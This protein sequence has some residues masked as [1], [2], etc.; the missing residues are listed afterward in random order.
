MYSEQ[1]GKRS[2]AREVVRALSDKLNESQTIKMNLQQRIFL[3]A[4]LGEY[5]LSNESKWM[6]TKEKASR[7][8]GWFIPEFIDIAAK[9]IAH[10]FLQKDVHVN[11]VLV[12]QPFYE[13]G[14]HDNFLVLL[15]LMV[16][17]VEE[18]VEQLVVVV[19]L[20]Q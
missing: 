8:N 5:M 13:Q 12:Q 4:K 7:E 18:Q 20:L 11:V 16:L 10:S 19:L 14:E 3:L 9:N 17:Q 2:A 15:E 6:E 1:R